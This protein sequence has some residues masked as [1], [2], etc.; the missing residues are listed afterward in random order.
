LGHD[1]AFNVYTSSRTNM[2]TYTV[3][4]GAPPPTMV[5]DGRLTDVPIVPVSLE[6]VTIDGEGTMEGYRVLYSEWTKT[7]DKVP[8]D[9]WKVPRE[10]YTRG[11]GF[12]T[13]VAAQLAERVSRVKARLGLLPA[14]AGAK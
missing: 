14:K 12:R 7:M 2:E 1:V 6:G 5:V 8:E 13:E 3:P 9:E 11:G 4:P 10:C